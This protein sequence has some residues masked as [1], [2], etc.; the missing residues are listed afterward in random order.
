MVLNF[1]N[2]TIALKEKGWQSNKKTRVMN[3]HTLAKRILT[4]RE[5]NLVHLH[6][7]LHCNPGVKSKNK[8]KHAISSDIQIIWATYRQRDMAVIYIPSC[9]HCIAKLT[10]I[11]PGV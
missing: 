6:N 10:A 5:Y 1:G 2:Q 11:I 8:L 7:K 4:Y 9:A 3:K